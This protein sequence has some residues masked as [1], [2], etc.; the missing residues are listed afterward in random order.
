MHRL[1]HFVKLAKTIQKSCHKLGDIKESFL[2]Q[3][4]YYGGI[5]PWKQQMYTNTE[6][7]SRGLIVT[8]QM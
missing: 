3:Q 8:G 4:V 6:N 5:I 2:Q 1:Y 7:C